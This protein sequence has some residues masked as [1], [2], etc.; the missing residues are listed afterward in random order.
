VGDGLGNT[1]SSLCHQCCH[2]G[3]HWYHGCVIFLSSCF[4]RHVVLSSLHHLV[5][6]ASSRHLV[7]ISITCHHLVII[8]MSL[9]HCFV[10]VA[11]SYHHFVVFALSRL[12]CII[13]S[14]CHCLVIISVFCH[15]LI[16]ISSSS[17][18]PHIIVLHHLIIIS[19]SSHYLVLRWSSRRWIFL[20]WRETFWL[21]WLGFSDKQNTFKKY[22]E[23]KFLCCNVFSI[24]RMMYCYNSKPERTCWSGVMAP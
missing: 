16:I 23:E 21:I 17:H 20:Y 19:L 9:H 24:Y 1:S 10:F 4:C 8:S 11:S 18:H 7:I 5:F 14:S 6:I 15:H 13:S 2:L 3:S 12:C 22:V